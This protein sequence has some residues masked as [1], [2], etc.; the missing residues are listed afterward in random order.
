[1]RGFLDRTRWSVA[2]GAILALAACGG[3]DDGAPAA[4]APSVEPPKL[5]VLVFDRSTSITT[6]ELQLYDR[7]MAQKLQELNHGDRVA[8]IELLQLSLD[9]AP[10]RW[11]QG[12]PEREFQ[13]RYAQRDSVSLAR[14]V[15]NTRDYL[16]RFSDPDDRDNFLGTDILSTLWDVA[17]EVRAYPDHRA[18][19]VLFSDMLQATQEMNME[20]LI[21]MPPANWVSQRAAQNRLPDLTGACIVVVGARTDTAAG[22]QV[23][24]FWEEY[25]E[26]TGAILLDRNYSYRPVQIPRDP[27]PGMG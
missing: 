3:G 11:A 23:K 7:L 13:N 21:R 2:A 26:A 6:E 1:M 17:E 18:T 9:E 12:V 25:F 8:A 16:R 5:F 24:D 14:F 4:G 15:Q 27:C 20:G 22:Q 10:Q 19:V